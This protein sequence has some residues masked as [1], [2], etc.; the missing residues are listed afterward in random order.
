MTLAERMIQYRARERI[1]QR[2]LAER[3]GLS[4]QTVNSVENET[5]T[6]SKMTVA[7][8][9]LVIGQIKMQ[10]VTKHD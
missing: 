9:E 5:Q 2:E 6:P 3:C 1:N 8:I 10:E 4:L 7:K